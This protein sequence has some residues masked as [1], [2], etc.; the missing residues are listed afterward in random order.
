MIGALEEAGVGDKTIIILLKKMIL[1][2]YIRP[3]LNMLIDLN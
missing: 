2:A 3:M 1:M